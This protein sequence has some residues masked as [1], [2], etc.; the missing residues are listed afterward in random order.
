M[1]L[2]V[3][4]LGIGA[5]EWGV[6]VAAWALGMFLFEWVWGS[7]SD[8]KDRRQLMI[9]SVL[10]MSV[11]FSLFTV[12][13]LIPYF[14]ILS[15]LS[16]AV[17]VA[18]GPTSRAYVSDASSQQSAGLYASLW[19]VSFLLGQ[20]I[21]PIVGAFIAQTWSFEYAFYASSVLAIILAFF[22]HQSL[23]P[24]KKTVAKESTTG[25]IRGLR[26]VL[27]RPAARTLFLSTIFIFVG[28]ALVIAFLPL[29]ASSV[30]KMSTFEVGLLLAALSA[31]QLAAMPAVGW[32][33]DRFGRH[34][35]AVLVYTAAAFIF[36]MYFAVDS[37]YQMFLVSIALGVGLSG[38][39]LLL[40]LIP[41]V[42]TGSTY[43]ATVGA[44]GSC[45]DLG[46][47]IGPLLFGFVW[48]AYGPVYIFAV[49]SV[50]QLL[51][52][53]LLL[54]MR[55]IAEKSYKESSEPKNENSPS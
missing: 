39:S 27:S 13:S 1:P 11:L 7:L 50:T 55:R 15:L 33:S 9:L 10:G 14:I 37:A 48:S 52:A 16:G 2:Y 43:G 19:W 8:R 54:G 28:R 35:T 23:P 4:S 26:M 30:I 25:A 53:S 3:R 49:C 21:G 38:T 47:I 42:S 17:S 34:R 12:R 6:L 20:V 44:Y 22:I 51:G 18:I 31:T 45:E 41:T 36:L 5:V 32:I 24:D 46:I 40:S 29:Y